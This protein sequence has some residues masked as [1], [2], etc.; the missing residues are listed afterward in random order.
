M[1]AINY[2]NWRNPD[3]SVPSTAAEMALATWFTPEPKPKARRSSR[4]GA[5]LSQTRSYASHEITPT[6]E[7]CQWLRDHITDTL[8]GHKIFSGEGKRH[9]DVQ[10]IFGRTLVS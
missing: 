6:E 4:V 10:T 5:G 8:D 1:P 9:C 2:D 3:G 7:D